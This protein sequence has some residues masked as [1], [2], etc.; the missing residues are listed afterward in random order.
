VYWSYVQ[1]ATKTGKPNPMPKTAYCPFLFNWGKQHGKLVK[2][3]QRGDIFLVR[4][5]DRHNHTGIVTGSSGGSFQSIEGNT[6]NDGSRNGVGVFRRTRTNGSCDFVRLGSG[7]P[8]G[9]G[10]V[11]PVANGKIA[12]GAKVPQAFKNKVV[13][14][15]G[16]IGVNPSFLMAC[17]AFET[18]ESF[19]P[20]IKNGAGSGATGLIQFMPSTARSLGTST[21]ALAGMSAVQQLDYVKK[22]FQPY[23]NKLKTLEDVYLA[24]LY[25]AAIGKDPNSTLFAQGTKT[26]SQN[27]GFDS[28]RDGKIT[29][30][31]VSVKVREKYTKGMG[32]GFAG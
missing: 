23:R 17:M 2:T 30:A 11:P 18:G 24:I 9:G 31:E 26:Y 4:G 29:P 32:N 14:I 8:S 1:A 25:P 21:D 20:S 19:S 5:S 7:V 13:Q 22:Y 10:A 12:W 3:P 28:N 15:S 16:E 27:S 6:N